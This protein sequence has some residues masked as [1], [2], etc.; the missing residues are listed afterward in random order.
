MKATIYDNGNLKLFLP[1]N[2]R[3]EIKETKDKHGEHVAWTDMFEPYFINGSFTPIDPES[4]FIGLTSDPYIIGE[5]VTIED[6]G[7]LTVYGKVWH[8]PNYMIDSV[9]DELI[10]G[11]TV[12]LT[13]VDDYEEFKLQSHYNIK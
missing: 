12:E 11:N 1:E 6:N 7:D 9:V 8:Y 2:E 4:H 3:E 13:L 10:K 5:D